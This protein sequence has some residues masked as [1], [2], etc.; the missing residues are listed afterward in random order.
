MSRVYL[1]SHEIDLGEDF[2]NLGPKLFGEIFG[3]P[4]VFTGGHVGT[5]PTLVLADNLNHLRAVLVK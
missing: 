3:E 1:H 2:F 4:A 5:Q